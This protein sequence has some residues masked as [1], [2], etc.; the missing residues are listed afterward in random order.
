MDI[1]VADNCHENSDS[2]RTPMKKA[3]FLSFELGYEW[4]HLAD[5]SHDLE[6]YDCPHDLS[7]CSDNLPAS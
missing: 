7:H 4:S 5:L 6:S 2:P 3:S 1:Q